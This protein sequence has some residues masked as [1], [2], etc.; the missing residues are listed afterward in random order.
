M[1]VGPTEVLQLDTGFEQRLHSGYTHTG[2]HK[3]VTVRGE[4]NGITRRKA[5]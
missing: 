1:V 5:R 4:G 3:T 2:T